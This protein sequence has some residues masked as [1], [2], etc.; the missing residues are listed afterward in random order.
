MVSRTITKFVINKLGRRQRAKRRQD[1]YD[2]LKKHDLSED[3]L[4]ELWPYVATAVD[5]G[6]M[7]TIA[8]LAFISILPLGVIV[9]GAF[10]AAEG[11]FIMS[12]V[13]VL[14]GLV[15]G[16]YTSWRVYKQWSHTQDLISDLKQNPRTVPD[17]NVYNW[18]VEKTDFKSGQAYPDSAPITPQDALDHLDSEE[19]PAEGGASGSG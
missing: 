19:V 6:G 13:I 3:E 12:A 8:V 14:I 9:F 10:V 11:A 18:L 4:A 17:T 1:I 2:E 16:R 15:V 7:A 5:H